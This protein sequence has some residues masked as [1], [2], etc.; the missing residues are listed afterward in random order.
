MMEDIDRDTVDWM[1]TYDQSDREPTVVPGRFPNFL[2]NGGEG[3]AVGM[4]TK[5]PPHNLKEVCDACMLLLDRPDASIEEIMKM[6]PGPDF[7]TAGIILGTRGIKEAFATGRGKVIMQAQVHI[8]PMD[9][10][11]N[12]IIVTELPYQVIKKRLI[13]NIAD[14]ARAKKVDGITNI[15]DLTDRHGMRVVIE[16]RRDAHPR[17]VLNY[18]LKHTALRTTFGVITLALVDNQPKLLTLPQV[19]N[20]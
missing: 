17:K 9:G 10:G 8:E 20:H 13:E 16:L 11:K 4:S 7:P 1:P 6:L 5:V 18:L 12:A 3:I 19:I 2:C 14:L 15:L